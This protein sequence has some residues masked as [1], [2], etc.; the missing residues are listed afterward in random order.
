[1]LLPS[2]VL[3]LVGIWIRA[4]A[5]DP[6]ARLRGNRNAVSTVSPK[7][8]VLVAR[9]QRRIQT[10]GTIVRVMMFHSSFTEIGITA[11]YSGCSACRSAGRSESSVVLERHAD[12]IAHGFCAS[13]A[14]LLG[15]SRHARPR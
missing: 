10:I 7:P 8:L 9:R 3:L 1:L 11:G 14:E 4:G 6:I 15:S 5:P 12:Q 2:S 13:F